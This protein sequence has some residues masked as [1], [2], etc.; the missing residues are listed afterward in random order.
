MPRPKVHDEELR[1]GILDSA[2]RALTANGP[3]G[4]SLRAI[5]A[6]AGTSTSAVYS[7]FG[8]KP[9][10]VHALY[11]EAFRRFREHLVRVPE[12]EDPLEDLIRLGVA[13]RRNA[14]EN[15]HLYSIMFGRPVPGFEP[16][17]DACETGSG[18]F[19]VLRGVV[20]RAVSCGLIHEPTEQATMRAWALVHGL[21]S[22]E[23]ADAVPPDVAATVDYEAALR[24][25]F[26]R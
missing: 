1:T 23:L 10:L 5:A 21:V 26:P 18:A 13:Y 17:A 2:G 16:G 12:T 9:E 20:R 22:L 25:A 7:L 11:T 3:H 15:P 4:L 19:D 14:L 8:G 6:D 24:A